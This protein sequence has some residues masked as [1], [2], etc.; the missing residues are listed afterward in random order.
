MTDV[1]IY[2]LITY[3]RF[4]FVLFKSGKSGARTWARTKVMSVLKLYNIIGDEEQIIT[5]FT[6][7]FFLRTNIYQTRALRHFLKMIP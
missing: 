4:A 3:S 5:I 1:D 7:S 6:M 2:T